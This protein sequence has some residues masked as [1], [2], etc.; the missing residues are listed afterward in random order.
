M[1]RLVSML[2]NAG[3]RRLALVGLAALV[4]LWAGPG[5]AAPDIRAGQ[6]L[7]RVHCAECHAI[8]R[9][10][11]STRPAATPFRLIPQRYPVEALE[12][13]FGEGITGSH[14]GM[15]D[16]AFSPRQVDDLLGYIK[17]L[18]RRR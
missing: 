17:S 16:F 7:A 8:G 10:G 6:A 4:A 1:M 14:K 5:L 12:E 3:S 13:A 2:K 18:G 11:R 15:P 9:S